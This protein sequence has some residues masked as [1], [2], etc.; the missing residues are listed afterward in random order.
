MTAS[1]HSALAFQR[2]VRS[3]WMM[4]CRS[5]RKSLVCQRPDAHTSDTHFEL[6]GTAWTSANRLQT[7]R[8]APGKGLSACMT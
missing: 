1:S 2:Q 7:V 3:R 6:D 8:G 5:S 4:Q